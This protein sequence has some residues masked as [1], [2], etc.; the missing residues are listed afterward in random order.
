MA[1]SLLDIHYG[2]TESDI[3][4]ISIKKSIHTEHAVYW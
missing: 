4:T 1:F 2:Q 3:S